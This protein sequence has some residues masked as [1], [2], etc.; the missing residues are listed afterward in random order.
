M[1]VSSSDNAEDSQII[2]QIR[3]GFGREN[4]RQLLKKSFK[5]RTT[6]HILNIQLNK[7]VPCHIFKSTAF[8]VRFIMVIKWKKCWQ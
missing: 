1:A 7:A 4:N 2:S 8:I 5:H 3:L 6:Y